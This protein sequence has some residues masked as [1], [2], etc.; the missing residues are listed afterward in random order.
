M[1]R[2]ELVALLF[3]D[4]VGRVQR[5]GDRLSF[6]Y[7]ERWRRRD[8]VAPVSLSMPL[9]AATHGHRP[10]HTYLWGLL[11]DNDRVLEAWGREFHVAPRNPF[12][13]LAHVGEDCAGAIQFAAPERVPALLEESRSEIEWQSEEAIGSS[14]RS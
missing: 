13:L 6:T 8:D 5:Q 11:P 10:T 2:Q 1:S 9:A 14:T 7:E 12:A 4:R 3:G